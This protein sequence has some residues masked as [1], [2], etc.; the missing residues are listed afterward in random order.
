MKRRK[1][2]ARKGIN[3]LFAEAVNRF[4]SPAK[5]I[6]YAGRTRFG[7]AFDPKLAKQALDRWIEKHWFTSWVRQFLYKGL[8]KRIPV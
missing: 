8:Y 7:K 6:E 1:N 5:V 2:P 4:G 3:Q